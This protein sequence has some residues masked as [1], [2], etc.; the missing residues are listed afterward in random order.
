M[1]SRPSLNFPCLICIDSLITP[2]SA[3]TIST[4]D[5]LVST[6]TW[7]QSLRVI[8]MGL[9]SYCWLMLN[10]KIS[11]VNISMLIPSIEWYRLSKTSQIVV[12][13]PDFWTLPKHH[14]KGTCRLSLPIERWCLLVIHVYNYIHTYPTYFNI[15]IHMHTKKESP[16]IHPPPWFFVPWS[17]FAAFLLASL[18]WA[19]IVTGGAYASAPRRTNGRA[20]PNG[21]DLSMG[22][23][24]R[25]CWTKN[26]GY[27][28]MDGLSYYSN[29]GW[30]IMDDFIIMGGLSY[31]IDGWWFIMEHPIF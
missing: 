22:S 27:P 11:Q 3:I 20:R 26:K 18:G 13:W 9:I 1:T 5:T 10:K 28:K 15:C 16:Y 4:S 7:I 6:W 2:S 30:F 14:L 19:W 12:I 8:Q 31:I 23:V 25:G 24:I 21:I 29:N 17:K